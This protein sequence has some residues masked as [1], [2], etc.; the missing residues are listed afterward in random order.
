MEPVRIAGSW[1]EGYALCVYTTKSVYIEDDP[2][3]NP[4]FDTEYSE[5]GKLLH[6]MKYNGHYDTSA[7]IAHICKDFLRDWLSDKSID[8]VLPVP[9]SR[10][11]N[12]QPVFL[13]AEAIA[14]VLDVP[15]TNKVLSKISTQ[16]AK[17]IPPDE[18]NLSGMIK[19]L[20]PAKR[21]CNILLVD[22]LFQTGTTANECV[23]VLK[24]DKLIKDIYFFGYSEK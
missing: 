2:F 6:D 8:V 24:K 17:A 16:E 13:V 19:M 5:I 11:R 22:D 12:T 10:E 9:P 15:Y 4:V 21:A 3:G 14:S 23:S 18:R 1:R 20:S 7:R